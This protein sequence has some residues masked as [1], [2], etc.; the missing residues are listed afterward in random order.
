MKFAKTSIK[1][2]I[3]EAGSHPVSDS[4]WKRLS[5]ITGVSIKELK[6][7]RKE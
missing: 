2:I 4:A 1:R 7:M 6:K 3:K 5:D